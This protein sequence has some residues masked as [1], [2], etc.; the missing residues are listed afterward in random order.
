M[1]LQSKF[2]QLLMEIVEYPGEYN[3]V[4][5]TLENILEKDLGECLQGNAL[6]DSLKNTWSE[7][8]SNF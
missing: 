7:L 2:W 4:G 3:A 5:I 8:D 6:G 1:T